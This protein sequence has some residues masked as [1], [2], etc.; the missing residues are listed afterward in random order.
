MKLIR[1]SFSSFVVEVGSSDQSQRYV[2]IRVVVK[3]VVHLGFSHR[4]TDIVKHLDLDDNLP[5]LALAGFQIQLSSYHD[6]WFRLQSLSATLMTLHDI[7]KSQVN[8]VMNSALLATTAERLGQKALEPYSFRC[9]CESCTN[10][11]SD[12]RRARAWP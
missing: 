6:L 2:R 10:P 12:S 7:E 8:F 3:A 5:N 1:V 9:N 11:R 4:A